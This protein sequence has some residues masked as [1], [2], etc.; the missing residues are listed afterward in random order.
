MRW[1]VFLF[2]AAPALANPLEGRWGTAAQC[3]GLPIVAGGTRLAAPVEVGAEWL[4]Q[5]EVWC[6][7]TWFAAQPR[8]DGLFRA[9]RAQCGEDS[10]RGYNLGFALEGETLTL[11]WDEALVN[12]PLSRCE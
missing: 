8:A 4:K 5:G 6:R 7:L 1:L 2:F 9:A 12:G 11:L 3:A 10:V